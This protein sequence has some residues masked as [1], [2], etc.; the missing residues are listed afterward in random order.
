MKTS[1]FV[2]FCFSLVVLLFSGVHGDAKD[3]LKTEA[4]ENLLFFSFVVILCGAVL[5]IFVLIELKFHWIPE[6]VA[7]VIYGIFIG[8]ILKFIKTDVADHLKTFDPELF[9]LFLLPS[10][11]FESGFSLQKTPFFANIGSIITLALLG[12]VISF[13]FIGGSLFGLSK[14]GL[15][16][17]L[18]LQESMTSGAMLST[19][20]TVAT[21]AIFQ[22]LNVDQQLYMIVF[23]ESVLNDAVGFILFRASEHYHKGEILQTFTVFFIVTF[24]SIFLGIAVAL[25]LS[26]ILRF[27]NISRYPPLETIFMI[28]FSYMSYVLADSLELSGILSVFFCGVVFNHYGSYSLSPYTTLTSRQLFRTLAF[29]C[30]TSVFIYIGISL[31]TLSMD[32]DVRLIFSVIVSCVAGRFVHVFLLCNILNFFKTNKLTLKMQTAIWFSGLMRG[33]LAFSLSFDLTSAAAPK[34]K[35]ATLIFVHFT[36]FVMGCGTLPLLKFL[37]I[38]S[39]SSDQSLEHI[40]KPHVKTPH[41]GGRKAPKTSMKASAI[42]FLK[43]VDADYLKRWLRKPMPPLAQEAIDLFEQLVKVSNEPP[44]EREL[45]VYSPSPNRAQPQSEY[46][47][48]EFVIDE[49]PFDLNEEQN[50]EDSDQISLLNNTK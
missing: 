48:P 15:N 16:Y 37:K 4:A 6:S 12:T 44:R 28:M 35:S 30:E 49:Q 8:L 34:I 25:V 31:P 22:A 10:I 24:G 43:R 46:V 17:P 42:S 3:P 47:Q 32:I 45:P 39:A 18:T 26:I 2:L 29:V 14:I 33:A 13:G 7:V 23:G 40:S 27:I 9:F 36:L 19:T 50:G 1:S 20:D 11:I 21:L 38:E 41:Q 5:I